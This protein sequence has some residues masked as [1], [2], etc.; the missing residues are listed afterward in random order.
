MMGR[1]AQVAVLADSTKFNRRLF[2]QVAE[3]GRADWFVS[4]AM[5]PDDLAE[6]FH[7]AGV[8]VVVPKDG[9]PEQG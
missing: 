7:A 1:A 4:D 9:A 6:A 2:A 5:P 8:E 3:L